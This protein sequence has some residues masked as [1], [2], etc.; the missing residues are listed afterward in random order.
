V[1]KLVQ[2]LC[3]CNLFGFQSSQPKFSDSYRI[4]VSGK[5]LTFCSIGD[6]E[7]TSNF[8][9]LI[10]SCIIHSDGTQICKHQFPQTIDDLTFFET[11]SESYGALWE[12]GPDPSTLSNLALASAALLVVSAILNLV[13]LLLASIIFK[14][15]S[16]GRMLI[17][18]VFFTYVDAVVYLGP[19]VMWVYILVCLWGIGIQ[20]LSPGLILLVFAFVAKLLVSINHLRMICRLA[21]PLVIGIIA[22]LCFCSAPAC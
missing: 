4:G 14:S 2:R 15:E 11:T 1:T 3:I 19:L 18:L 7:I 13:T 20:D 21:K 16:L 17:V 9:V 22:C 5:L 12:G 8:I 10:G 6:R